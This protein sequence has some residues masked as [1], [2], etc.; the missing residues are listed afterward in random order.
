[1]TTQSS[2]KSLAMI[3]KKLSSDWKCN[4]AGTHITFRKKFHSYLHAFMFLT[5][6]SINAEVLATYPD[7]HL[8][9][10][11]L[12]ITVGGIAGLTTADIELAERIDD[13]VLSTTSSN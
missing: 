12:K 4:E 7:I 10:S 13:M 2:K 3:A 9:K 1:M 8:S 5:R 6:V 11:E